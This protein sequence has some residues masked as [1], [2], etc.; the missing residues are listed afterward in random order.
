MSENVGAI[1]YTVD[2]DTAAVTKGADKV[3]AALDSV[4][5]GA[6]GLD[7]SMS[8]ASSSMNDAAKA[9][10]KEAA[11][12]RQLL[13]QINPTVAATQRLDDMT[14][15]LGKAFDKGQ[16]SV[17]QYEANLAT[18]NS[19]YGKLE[20]GTQKASVSAGGFGAKLTPLAGLV[21]GVVTA[22]TLASW[23]KLAEQF[24]LLQ[25]R[26]ARL[27]PDLSTASTTYSQLL[28]IAGQTGQ[29]MPATVK[30]WETL[31]SSLKSLGA[32]NDQ[33]VSLT[34][35]LQ[36]IG[37][38]GGS[39]ADET[40]NALRQL[41]QS[42]SGG[43]L[44]AEE[45]NS[46]VEQTP[47][48]VRQLA[49]GAGMSMGQFRQ[50]MLD[51][52]I[53]S[54]ELFDLLQ[55]RTADVDAEFNKLPRSVTDAANAISV[56]F[57]AALSI[58]DKASKASQTLAMY[59]DKLAR[60]IELTFNPTS[61][62]QFNKLLADRATLMESLAKEKDSWFPNEN[63]IKVIGDEISGVTAKIKA[64]QDAE[65]ARQKA[66]KAATDAPKTE[67]STPKGTKEIQDLKE[68]ND[69]LQKEGEARAVLAALQQAGVSADS[70]EGK[71]IAELAAANYQLQE[72]EKARQK[73]KQ[74]G[75]SAAKKAETEAA[76]AIKKENAEAEKAYDANQKVI[77][78]LSEA[79]AEASLKGEDLAVAQAK[80]KLNKFA[81]PEDV[82]E[83]ERLTKAIQAQKQ[84][85]ATKTLANT[86]DPQ[87]GA[88]TTV[89]QQLKDIATV[90][91]AGLISA[92]RASELKL[93]AEA[94]YQSKVRA[95][96]EETFKAASTGNALL[97]NSIDA[98]GQSGTQALSGL[99]SGTTSLKDA[100]GGVA[101][102]VLNE[103]IGALVQIGVNYVKSLIIGQSAGAA[104]AAAS[105]GEATVVGA[106]WAPA[107][108]FAS[109]ATLGTNAAPAAAAMTSTVGLA[110]AL[111]LS[112][113]R[114]YGGP[115]AGG[116]MY[117][118]NE[119]GAPEI[120]NAAGGKQYMM[121][122]SR[123]EVVSNKDATSGS[124]GSGAVT[125]NV[126][127]SNGSNVRVNQRQLDRQQII[128]VFVED[129]STGGQTR[130]LV[131]QVTGTKSR[132][133]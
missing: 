66:N 58:I 17:K 111:Q 12:L 112:G 105:V 81:T 80:T 132:G 10:D 74:D 3:N 100:L 67:Q 45:F 49:A 133:S 88:K 82:A 9:T 23:G 53:T 89:D 28:S 22:S 79:L 84:A 91:Q 63:R 108:A 14:E 128:D 87:V 107:A 55:K 93:A 101:N 2:M 6:T 1:T 18:L 38:I 56:Q 50:A 57:G 109:L 16:I 104:A 31:T 131:N 33:V 36:K 60:G 13:G 73:S 24:T 68:K 113:A 26:I 69:L 65:V 114:Q 98:L 106:A 121:P 85:Q 47:E 120:F 48:L 78:G 129:I 94:D 124:S 41:G 52:K 30:L 32:T 7:T 118:V 20:G 72:A 51:G 117:R 62:D 35:T 39:S 116:S 103:V 43:T 64:M 95:L 115:V 42:L 110:S 40:A 127:N 102:T 71:R 97:L 29:T 4:G 90:E 75:I 59:M 8:R 61:A 70:A 15:A 46:I 125:V 34:S 21:A 5:R 54:A 37:K 99:L 27:T 130:K 92:Q 76:N 44:R 122:N 86:V 83:V 25:A 77:A 123:G 126:N 19:Q 96:Q 11:A 119:G